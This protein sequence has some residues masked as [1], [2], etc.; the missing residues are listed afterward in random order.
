M[1]GT[2]PSR[3]QGRQG[4]PTQGTVA[5]LRALLAYRP[6]SLDDLA[7]H[8]LEGSD[9]LQAIRILLR[10]GRRLYVG[11][12]RLIDD[13]DD[14]DDHDERRVVYAG[15]AAEDERHAYDGSVSGFF[16]LR[17]IRM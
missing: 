7:A 3:R 1:I 10:S 11:D 6:R 14:H 9:L 4:L 5:R 13:H 16:E 2:L 15:E 17:R 12:A 8:A